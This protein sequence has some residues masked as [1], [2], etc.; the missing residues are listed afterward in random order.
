MST[1]EKNAAFAQAAVSCHA[2]MYR[3]ALG[4]LH[5]TADAEDAVSNAVIAA[6]TH[7][8][9]LREPGALPGYLMQCTIHACHAILRRKKHEI[10][11]DH[12]EIYGQTA[13]EPDSVWNYVHHLPEKYRVPLL[14][15]YGEDWKLEEIAKALRLPKG[16][17]SARL[18]RA[19]KMLRKEL[20][21]EE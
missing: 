2:A 17:V 19:L 12:M 14:L 21:E 7:L 11:A 15:R 9:R 3:V 5:S 6:W 1:E 18:S 16:T 13:E 10:S 20:Q 4:M 8:H